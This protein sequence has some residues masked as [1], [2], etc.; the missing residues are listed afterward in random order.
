MDASSACANVSSSSSDV[1]ERDG[2]SESS[3]EISK[4]KRSDVWKYFKKI[5][6]QKKALCKLCN[7][8][9]AYQGGTTNVKHQLVIC[10]VVNL[11]LLQ[12]ANEYGR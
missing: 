5:D 3:S 10:F 2:G 4:P 6:E 8:D 1:S 11:S 12:G 7:K 9:L